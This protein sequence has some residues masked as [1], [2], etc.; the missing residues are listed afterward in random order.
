MDSVDDFI[1]DVHNGRWDLVLQAVEPLRLP[2]SKLMLLYEQVRLTLCAWY[3]GMVVSRG[4]R[5]RPAGA[6]VPCATAAGLAVVNAMSVVVTSAFAGA[7][8]H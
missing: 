2:E 5:P 1:S 4:R 6:V 8:L 7:D 3:M